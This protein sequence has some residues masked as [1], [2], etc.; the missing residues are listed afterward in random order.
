[1]LPALTAMR[2]ADLSFTLQVEA[3][4]CTFRDGGAPAPVERLLAARGANLVRL[5]V[6]VDPPAGTSTLA[7][8]LEL[9]RRANAAGCHLMLNLHY[10]DF[11]ADPFDQPTPAAWR[12]LDLDALAATVHDYTR[13]VVRAFL[14][15]GTPPDLV[16]I[17]NEISNG[18]LWPLGRIASDTPAEWDRL[19]LL[20]GAGAGAVRE[21][22][23]SLRVAVHTDTGGDRARAERLFGQLERRGVAADVAAVSF[24]PWW[25][26]PVANLAL[27]LDGLAAQFGHQVA[28]VETSY[29]WT[30][31]D[32]VVGDLAALHVQ[33]AS[34]LPEADRFPPTP[35]GQAAFLDALR[36]TVG[37]VRDGAGLGFAVW[38]PEWLAAVG[39]GMGQPNRFANLTLFDAKGDALPGVRVFT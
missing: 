29:P 23:P 18:F 20:V 27:T 7:A 38:E 26:G 28:V 24:F 16:Q 4:G 2:G 8:A 32:G 25:H 39:A 1:V 22:D 9:G 6:W 13:D 3:A 15:Q 19:A 17:G 12:H 34:Q 33:R 36:T 10:A 35:T 5:R 21:V 14:A 31:D 30:V 11:W 37:S